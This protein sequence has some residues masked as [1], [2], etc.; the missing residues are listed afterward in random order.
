MKYLSVVAVVICVAASSAFAQTGSAKGKGARQAA[1][2]K[3]AAPAA[4]SKDIDFKDGDDVDGV[5]ANGT[6]DDVSVLPPAAR[7]NLIKVRTSFVREMLRSAE[8][9]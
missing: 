8:S 6:G 9:L 4:K 1:P 7:T 3:G 5:R 2:A